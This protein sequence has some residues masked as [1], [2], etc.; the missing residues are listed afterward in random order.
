MYLTF[1]KSGYDT[2]TPRSSE[3]YSIERKDGE[4]WAVVA[5]G[6]AYGQDSYLFAVPTLVD[7]TD[8][9][10]GMTEFRV[11]AA[12][13]EGNF[14]SET[15]WGYS[16]DNIAPGPPD[17]FTVHIGTEVTQLSW[18]ESEAE[19]FQYFNIYRGETEDFEPTEEDLVHQTAETA[20]DDPENGRYYKLSAVDDAGNEGEAVD[21]ETVTDTLD[22]PSQFAL[23]PCVPNPFNPA[24]TIRFSLPVD[25]EVSLVVYDLSGRKIS[26]LI[27][28]EHLSRGD[29]ETVWNG[30]DAQGQPVA[31]GVYFYRLEAEGFTETRKMTL[32]K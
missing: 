17:G 15:A 5:S 13:D 11:V 28:Q 29:H 32:L 3:V 14:L 8:A 30:T 9:G 24:T 26:D 16:V 7:S 10:D 31:S 12:M 19:D 18:Q 27:S 23:F 4:N 25:T 6:A 1:T 22:S 2:D 21:P 20:W